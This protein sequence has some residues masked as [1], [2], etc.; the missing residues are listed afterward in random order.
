MLIQFVVLYKI[1]LNVWLVYKCIA[2]T[3]ESIVS[4]CSQTVMSVW[5]I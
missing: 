4:L 1:D 2:S 3:N 5:Y